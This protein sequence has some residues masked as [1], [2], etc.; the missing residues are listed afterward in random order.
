MTD[1]FNISKHP[2]AQYSAEEEEN[3]EAIYFEQQNYKE[4]IELSKAG[5]SRFILG[6][7]GQGKSAT[8]HHLINDLKKCNILPVLITRYDGFPEKDNEAY[9]LYSMI[10]NT[11]FALAK[12]MY[13]N[14]KA[15][16][17]LSV[18]QRNEIG[19]LIQAFYD[20]LL[21][22]DFIEQSKTIRSIRRE[23]FWKRLWNRFGVGVANKTLSTATQVTA[24]I[25]QSYTGTTP[26]FSIADG[27]YFHGVKLSEIHKMSKAEFVLLPIENLIKIVRNLIVTS[28]NLGY[29]SI[30]V[31]YDQIDEVRGINSDVQKVADFLADFLQDTEFLYTRNL[32]IVISLWSEVRN[33]L[34]N[35]NIRFDKFKEI[36]IR[37]RNEELVRLLDKRLL[38]YS[39]DKR[40]PVT[41]SSLI[42]D[43]HY[44]NVILDLAAGSPRALLTLMSYIQ[45]EEIGDAPVKEF[46]T[47]A[48]SN[49]SMAF[50]KKFDYVSL[51]PSRTGKGNDLK[52]WINKILRMRLSVFSAKQYAEFFNDVPARNV[53]KHIELMVKLNLI[54]DALLPSDD[55]KPLYQVVDPR[56]VH[57]LGRGV[58]EIE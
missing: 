25:I 13:A 56:I 8:I 2:F 34:N 28:N 57:M 41:F 55:G 20:Q 12:L 35:R 1:I 18:T 49:G 37:W 14:P 53:N 21:A 3:L 27:E 22:D 24:Q 45:S 29:N 50:C 38:Y 7:R 16:K 10:Q 48:I 23:N 43:E 36:D 44:Q 40:H 9:F 15:S 54:R 47:K 51:Q 39:D 19:T 33:L 58:L 4:I 52:A 30:V 6:Q 5:V 32:S 26:D 31:L 46:S 17:N 11:V 42:P